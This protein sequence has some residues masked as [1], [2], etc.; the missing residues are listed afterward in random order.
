MLQ[1]N[2]SCSGVCLYRL[3]ITTRGWASRFRTMTSR[4][5]VRAEVSSRMSAIPVS[6]PEFT[7]S[8]ILVARLSGLHMYG[9]S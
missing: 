5:P 9:N 7:S 8:A 3:F 4:C 1:P 2:V 6:R